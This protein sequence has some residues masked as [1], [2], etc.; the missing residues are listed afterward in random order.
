MRILEMYQSVGI[1]R[2]AL[3]QIPDGPVMA[4]LPRTLKLKPG[5]IYQ[6]VENPRGQ[7]GFYVAT[8]GSAIPCRVKARGP[9]FCNLSVMNYLCRDILL[10]D[11]PAIL[12]SIDV[13]LGEVDR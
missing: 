7:L 10:A 8:D 6:E 4:K 3:D 2:Q 11:I 1:I 9:C 5:E 13:V 12:A